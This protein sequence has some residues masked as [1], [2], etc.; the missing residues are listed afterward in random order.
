MQPIMIST[1]FSSVPVNGVRSQRPVCRLTLRPNWFAFRCVNR[2]RSARQKGVAEEI[3]QRLQPDEVDR[4]IAMLAA[5]QANPP[6][7]MPA[8]TR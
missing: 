8:D 3:E 2:T 4:A 5:L 1:S 7:S 6:T